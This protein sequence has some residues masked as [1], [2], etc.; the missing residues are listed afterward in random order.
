MSYPPLQDKTCDKDSNQGKGAFE[1]GEI[2]SCADCFICMLNFLLCNGWYIVLKQEQYVAWINSQLKKR[3]G[4]R[5]VREIP[6]DTRD[7]I[8][9]VQL[10]DVLGGF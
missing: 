5:F 1:V 2:S 10:I 8:A 3:P 4:S 9:L 6:R 7:G